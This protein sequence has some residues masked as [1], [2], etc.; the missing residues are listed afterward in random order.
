MSSVE[1]GSSRELSAE[2]SV[3]VS[4]ES[5][6]EDL[7]ERII[8]A[9][10][11]IV[12][13]EGLDALSMRAL[14]V[15]IGYSPATIYLHFQDKEELLRSVMEEG[16]KRLAGTVEDEVCRM[17]A[18]AAA[19]DQLAGTARAYARF[20]LENTGY[21][22][23]MFKM[24]AVPHLEGCPAPRAGGAVSHEGATALLRR[25]EA[26]GELRTGDPDGAALMGWGL[27]HGLTSLYLSGHLGDRVNGHEEF[28]E[29]IDRAINALQAGWK[30]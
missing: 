17:P 16:F 11:D 10:R 19:L 30:A 24:P 23:A 5:S 20:A 2:T 29:L 1:A 14:A 28:M 7:R 15:R 25:A 9:A 21:F 13:E 3:E 8:E 27:M 18:G 22:R 26:E 12:S 4:R 6:R